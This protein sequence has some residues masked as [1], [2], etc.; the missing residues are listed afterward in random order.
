MRCV[1]LGFCSVFALSSNLYSQIPPII[2]ILRGDSNN[3]ASVGVEDVIFIQE[4]LFD[5]G[6]TPSCLDAADVND[7]GAIDLSDSTYLSNYLYLGGSPPPAPFPYCGRDTTQDSL[8]C[9]SSACQ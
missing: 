4:Y 1:M 6:S 9:I 7:D 3:S 2:E 8:S 5:G